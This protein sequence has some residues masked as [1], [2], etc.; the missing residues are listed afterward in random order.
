MYQ[1]S[2]CIRISSPCP[3]LLHRGHNSHHLSESLHQCF[4]TLISD[5]DPGGTTW[6]HLV[7]V[8]QFHKLTIYRL[9]QKRCKNLF[10]FIYFLLESQTSPE[11][12]KIWQFFKNIN[13]IAKIKIQ[14]TKGSDVLLNYCPCTLHLLGL[15]LCRSG[16]L[17][18]RGVGTRSL[19]EIRC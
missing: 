19:S 4:D 17:N 13:H 14:S 5:L 1:D 7:Q 8:Q 18:V 12:L 6:Y 15:F 11:S 10:Y 16:I 9:C 2:R 3:H